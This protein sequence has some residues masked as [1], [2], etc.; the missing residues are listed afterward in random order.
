MSTIPAIAAPPE[1]QSPLLADDL[2]QAG[3]FDLLGGQRLLKRMPASRADVHATIVHGIPY[4]A[5]FFLTDHI[6][7]LSESDVAHVVG[8][9]TRT[10][11][12]QKDAP[13]KSMPTDLASDSHGE[14]SL[15]P[16]KP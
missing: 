9:S 16:K 14:T 10:L 6:T 2:T 4:S 8:V 15:A 13:K 12:R 5:L 3:T 7:V 1:S 11:R